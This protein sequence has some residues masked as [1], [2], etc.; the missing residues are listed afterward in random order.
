MVT[1]AHRCLRPRVLAL[2][3]G[4][5]GVIAPSAAPRAHSLQQYLVERY[6]G[7]VLLALEQLEA[8]ARR[9]AVLGVVPLEHTAAREARQATARAAER[10]AREGEAREAGVREEAR[11]RALSAAQRPLSLEEIFRKLREGK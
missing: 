10:A 5:E 8:L 2:I 3:R 7:R 6:K 11:L 9:G 4:L 1:E